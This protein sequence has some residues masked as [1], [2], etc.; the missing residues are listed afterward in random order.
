VRVTELFVCIYFKDLLEHVNRVLWR[1]N[2]RRAP[3]SWPGASSTPRLIPHQEQ[4]SNN[5]YT[6]LP[7]SFIMSLHL[8]PCARFIYF[9]RTIEIYRPACLIY[10]SPPLPPPLAKQFILTAEQRVSSRVFFSL[11]RRG[12]ISCSRAAA[13]ENSSAI[14]LANLI[15]SARVAVKHPARVNEGRALS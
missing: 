8:P 3:F 14:F 9:I 11:L 6:H 5:I 7:L 1:V 13:R 12:E 15:V 2:A 10:V 4:S